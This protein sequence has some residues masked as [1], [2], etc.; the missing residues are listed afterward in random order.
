MTKEE[1]KKQL[2]NSN[3]VL[4]E[5]YDKSIDAIKNDLKNF[6]KKALDQI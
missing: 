2:E 4:Q 3:R 5:E 1:I 6:K